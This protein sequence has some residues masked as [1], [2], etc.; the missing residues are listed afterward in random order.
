M[1]KGAALITGAS[2]GIGEEPAKLCAAGGY[3]LVLVAR[4]LDRP[5]TGGQSRQDATDRSPRAG[6][7]P[8]RPRRD[9]VRILINNAGFGLRGPFA[10]TDWSAGQHMIQVNITALAHLTRLFLPEMQR[11]RS[12]RILERRLHGGVRAGALHGARQR[13]DRGGALSGAGP[14]A[15]R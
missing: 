14:Y 11:R 2:S 7:G 6:R 8:R 4:S 5:G 15:V 1:A 10:E 3:S 13:G 9:T 12:G